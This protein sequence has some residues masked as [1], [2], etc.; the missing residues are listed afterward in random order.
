MGSQRAGCANSSGKKHPGRWALALI[1]PASHAPEDSVTK[2]TLDR[3]S[4]AIN[5]SMEPA[6]LFCPFACICWEQGAFRMH[7]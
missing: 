7:F 6:R 3:E 4:V 1:V 2:I 5:W